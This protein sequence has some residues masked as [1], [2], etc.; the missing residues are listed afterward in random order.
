MCAKL[1]AMKYC[2]PFTVAGLYKLMSLNMWFDCNSVCSLSGWPAG[3]FSLLHT[4]CGFHKKKNGIT[5]VV[6]HHTFNQWCGSLM[7]TSINQYIHTDVETRWSHSRSGG[8]VL[9]KTN[10]LKMSGRA[11]T[12]FLVDRC[13][14]HH[15][16]CCHHSSEA[17]ADSKHEQR[18]GETSSTLGI[19]AVSTVQDPRSSCHGLPLKWVRQWSTI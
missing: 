8:V 6:N 9:Q 18:W 13:V 17:A 2:I 5:V 11:P 7:L 3:C 19:K 16:A 14:A 10:S 12:V 15:E 4:N 1:L